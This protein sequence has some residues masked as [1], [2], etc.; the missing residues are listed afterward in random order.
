MNHLSISTLRECIALLSAGT[1][2]NMTVDF[3]ICSLNDGFVL[4]VKR[5]LKLR[6]VIEGGTLVQAIK[7]DASIC[8]LQPSRIAD[9]KEWKLSH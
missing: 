8:F 1:S 4:E 2:S 9:P 7:T 6:L 5:S 3:C